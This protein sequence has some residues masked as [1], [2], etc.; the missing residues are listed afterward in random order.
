MRSKGIYA[1]IA[2]SLMWSSAAGAKPPCPPREQGHV[3]WG[4]EEL[5]DGDHWAW[6]YL[7]IDKSGRPRDCRLGPNNMSREMLART[8]MSFMRN[9]KAV[10]VLENGQPVE[11]TIKRKFVAL[12]RAHAKANER[13]RKRF[14]LEHPG[15]RPECYPE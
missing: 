7:D 4:V 8:C 11:T 1:W 10:P 2:A 5:M 15:E 6:V 14:F 13:E 9:W 12:G 3:P